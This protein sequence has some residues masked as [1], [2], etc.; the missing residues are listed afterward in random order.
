MGSRDPR[1]QN[2]FKSPAISDFRVDGHASTKELGDRRSM[3]LHPVGIPNLVSAHQPWKPDVGQYEKV[4][5]GR[6]AADYLAPLPGHVA[7]VQWFAT[8]GKPHFWLQA[9]LASPEKK[10]NS[11]NSSA[12]MSW[13]HRNLQSA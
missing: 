9:C 11:Q 3:W 6:T 2:C 4:G 10:C 7:A 1:A 8:P 12:C 13:R 5:L